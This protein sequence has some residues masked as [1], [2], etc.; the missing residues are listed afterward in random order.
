MEDRIKYLGSYRPK[1]EAFLRSTVTIN[2]DSHHVWDAVGATADGHNF[3]R[4]LPNVADNAELVNL[5][6]DGDLIGYVRDPMMISWPCNLNADTALGIL[7]GR[8]SHA[9]L[10][11][12]GDDGCPMQTSKYFPPQ[13]QECHLIG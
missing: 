6:K 11:Y 1:S 4:L 12:A 2:G 8:V 3:A 9:E 10:G 5:V 13:G 7:K